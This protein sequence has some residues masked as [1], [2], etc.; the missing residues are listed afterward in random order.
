MKRNSQKDQLLSMIRQ[1]KPMTLG[2]QARLV[3]SL[4]TPAILA[5]LT[6][7]MMQY[8]DASMVGSLGAEASAAIGLI[9]TT[10]WLMGSICSATAAGFYVQVSHQLGAS[11]AARARRTLR[12]GIMSVFIVS[13]VIG[14][15]ALSI[16]P[17]LPVWLGG[18]ESICPTASAYFAIIAMAL[19]AFQFSMFGSGMLRSSG[20]MV[21]PS[22]MSVVMMTLDVI[23]NFFLIFDTR[24]VSLFGL[25][26]TLPGAGLGVVG[27]AIGTVSAELVAAS[28]T[29]YILCFRSRE[30]SLRIDRG[31]FLPTWDVV[32]KALHIGLPMGLQQ[33]IMT[34]A[35][36]VTTIIIAPLGTFAIA[37]NSFG[38]IVESLCYMPGYGVSD[39]AT[40]L[41]GQS[42]GAGRHE[43]MKRFAWLSV[44]LG[45]GIMTV[46]GV[47]MYVGSPFAMAMMTPSE[48]VRR[49]G[50]EVLRIEAFAEPM[51]GAAIICYGV[52][53]GAAKT[54][55]PSIM[56]LASMWGVRITLAALLAPSMG[57]RGVWLAMCL[58][59]CFRGMI[60]LVK[61]KMYCPS[62]DQSPT[63]SR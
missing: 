5:Q 11:D 19:P 8:I 34:S 38:I 50:V 32:G 40:T 60:F 23:F 61:L 35:Y 28:I 4:A 26:V 33:T 49:L 58:E 44:A 36:I 59:L 9:E 21:V 51:F 37:A 22:V 56:N 43:L 15:I 12:Q 14:L 55:V 18:N 39:A 2:Q 53:V 27:A 30:L 42:M 3:M 1:G 54:V 24:T 46:M 62:P 6:T 63:P 57:L 52:F 48:E 13:A 31:R 29:M 45:M 41:V 16:S 20:N 10:T 7:T 47:V 25:P 17:F